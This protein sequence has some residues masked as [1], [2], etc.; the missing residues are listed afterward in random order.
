MKANLSILRHLLAAALF[1]AS[2]VQADPVISEFM[3]QNQTTLKDGY[4]VYSDWIE[5]WNPATA[6]LDL[7][8]WRLTD[9]AT[10]PAKFVFPTLTLPPNGRLVVFA[11]DRS[12]STGALTHFDPLG[13]PHANFALSKDGEYLALIKPDGVTRTTELNPF[14]PQLADVSFGPPETAERLVGSTSPLRYQAP[15]NTQYDSASPDWTRPSFADAAWHAATGSGVGFEAGAPTAAWALDEPSGATAAADATGSGFAAALNGTG[16]TFGQPGAH[17]A[18]ATAVSFSGSGGLTVPYAA[19]LNPPATFT[20]AAWVYPTGG[21]GTYRTVVSSRVG[22]SGLQRGYILYL[23]P[24][25]T[26]EFWTGYPGSWQTLS[27]GAATLNAW[28]HLALSRDAAG[29]KRLFVNGVL[30]AAATQSYLPNNNPANGLHLGCGDDLGQQYRFIGRIDDA[31]LWGH[32][33]GAEL[34]G[35]HRTEGLAE[36]PTPLYPAHFQTDVHDT[37]RNVSPGLYTR[38]TFTV[39][40]RSR[41]SALRL[42]LKY[43]D[44]FVAFLNGTEILRR[45][46]SGARAFSAL[47]D[48]DREDGDAVTFEA[49]DVTAALPLLTDGTNTLAV[50]GMTCRPSATAFLLV[51]ELEAALVPEALPPGY[52]AAPTPGAPNAAQS[53]APGPEI[54]AAAHTPDPPAA[55]E[56]LTVSARITPRLAPIQSVTLLY[57]VN[58]GAESAP[59]ALADAG[60]YPGAT[61]GSRLYT[62]T[63]P[64]SHGAAARQMLRYRLTATDSAGRAWRAPY[65]TD[66]TNDDGVSQSPEYFGTVIADPTLTASM[67]ILQWF[68]ADV[69]NSDTRVGSRA[70]LWY[71]GR[72]YD[73]LYVRQRG[74]YTSYGSQ[75]FNFNRNDGLQ[76]NSTLGTVGEVNL[77]S[78]GADPNTF[79]V[80]AAY[81]AYRA[82]GHPAC[83]SFPVALLRNGTFHRIAHLIEQVDEDFLKRHGFDPDGALYKFVQRLG[84][85]VVNGDYSTSPA[86]KHES[87]ILGVEKKTRTHETFA[88]YAAFTA[89]INPT[90]SLAARRKVLFDNLNIPNFVNFMAVRALLAEIDVNRKNFYAYRDSDGSGEWFLFPWDKDM[91]LGV[92]YSTDPASNRNNPWQATDTFRHDPSG[93]RQWCV[94]WQNGYD[95]PEIRALVGRRLRTLMDGLLG[96]PG[97]PIPGSTPLEQAVDAVRAQLA[98]PPP[99]FT[100]GSAYA[101]R[102]SFNTWLAQHRTALYTTYG[103]ES[104]YGMIPASAAAPALALAALAPAPDTAAPGFSPADHEYL[105]LTNASPEAADLSGWTLWRAGASQPLFTFAPGTVVP[106]VGGAPLHRLHVSRNVAGFRSRPDAPTPAAAEYVVG[107]FT[108]R[109]ASAS[110]DTL[111]LRAG[112]GPDAPLVSTLAV[113]AAPSAAQR[114]LRLTELQFA[115]AAPTPAEL[116]LAPGTE[117]KHYEFLELAN[118]GAEALDLT[119]ARFTKG[120]DFDFP[121]LSLPPGQRTL[122]VA[123][124]AAFTARYGAAPNIAGVFSGSL[125]NTGE[126]LRLVDANGETV[127]DF[128]YDPRWF[129]PAASNGYSLVARSD[130]PAAAAYAEATFWALSGTPGGTPGAP[131]N[132]DFSHHYDGWLR[133]HFTDAALYLPEPDY[134]PDTRDTALVGH[135]ADPDGDG[136]INLAEYAFA[137]DP[138]TPDAPAFLLDTQQDAGGVTLTLTFTRPRQPLDLSYAIEA[139]DHPAGPWAADAF[140]DTPAVPLSSGLER[141]TFRTPATPAPARFLRLRVTQ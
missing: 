119:G 66:L 44:G 61:D 65:P 53:V 56:P 50:H 13:Y 86:F 5:I 76:V 134:P 93:T 129:P 33:I 31:A 40:D 121:A 30:K 108:G 84:E 85:S 118:I 88:D 43:D 83:E 101:N 92:S 59:V 19:A 71:A 8:G 110:S 114:F 55:G 127:L 103:P 35:L 131:D 54:R 113:A 94:L 39:A 48:L 63:I 72:F 96:A 87:P 79:R 62:G 120:V 51:P 17:A 41:Y 133:D 49:A 6:P 128:T 32:D 111:E 116:A 42:R 91:T 7:A 27:G 2:A 137:R 26:W 10:K 74:G 138:L 18:S 47:A 78:S 29:V 97:T 24:G 122:V 140:T 130:T 106:G 80:S 11:S 34:I 136:L 98:T 125:D 15:T 100:P 22:A 1:T 23:T 21:S 107:G 16:Q 38:H 73:N 67:P 64:A 20:F 90:N 132:G 112:S 14:P 123:D 104:A 45:N 28:T 58:Y 81:A 57:R 9:S 102:A 117:A 12:G 105:V 89:A 75:K 68:T 36:L 70:S 124:A 60:P 82:A 52:F 99:G 37:M 126:R 46:F 95:A 141:V 115:P 69:P 77:N 139:A 4:G 109:L 25:N 3:A 135:D